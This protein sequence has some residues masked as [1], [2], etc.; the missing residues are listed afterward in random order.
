MSGGLN[1]EP[2]DIELISRRRKE[3]PRRFMTAT[4]LGG[5][6]PVAVVFDGDGLLMDTE[7][8][9]GSRLGISSGCPDSRITS[10]R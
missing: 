9:V 6:M 7:P 10:G 4:V 1:G 3:I 8:S 5:W 2:G